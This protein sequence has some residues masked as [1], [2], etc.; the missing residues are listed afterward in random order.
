MPVSARAIINS[1]IVVTDDEDAT[2][3]GN[4]KMSMAEQ[5]IY[6]EADALQIEMGNIVA[7]VTPSG[8]YTYNTARPRQKKDRY[9]SLAMANNF[10][11]EMEIKNIRRRHARGR[12]AV[13]GVV[14]GF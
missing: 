10:V 2:M 8:N 9:S 13:I 14:S 7:T 6:Y 11:T 12:E 4:G 5:A 1:N 3:A